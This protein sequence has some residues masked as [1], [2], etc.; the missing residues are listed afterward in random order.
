MPQ[1]V[2]P[3]PKAVILPQPWD[4]LNEQQKR[5]FDY[6][7]Q[8]VAFDV[9]SKGGKIELPNAQMTD[10]TGKPVLEIHIFRIREGE[11]AGRLG[12]K[13]I[14]VD[15]TVRFYIKGAD[16]KVYEV[17]PHE[18]RLK[19]VGRQPLL[20]VRWNGEAR[21]YERMPQQPA[22]SPLS[23]RFVHAS[24]ET[25]EIAVRAMTSGAMGRRKCDE[26]FARAFVNNL[27]I[28]INKMARVYGI[29]LDEKAMDLLLRMFVA[30]AAWESDW[31]PK[32]I[33]GSYMGYW[34]TTI[35]RAKGLGFKAG[36]VRDAG[37]RGVMIGPALF[38]SV[39]RQLGKFR[40]EGNA[41]VWQVLWPGFRAHEYA[42]KVLGVDL[43]KLAKIVEVSEGRYR[44][45]FA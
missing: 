21:R 13:C 26:R 37:L 35:G 29:S 41:H 9:L 38:F 39:L 20:D 34:Q 25:K 7:F 27:E 45:V 16:G 43:P 33:T 28:A 1:M 18:D 6:F 17:S 23:R 2:A 8:H 22:L 30:I 4:K 14:L 11:C 31:K 44:L 19:G 5:R 24:D 40:L 10:N 3:S 42:L 15:G 32:C 36:D 12:A